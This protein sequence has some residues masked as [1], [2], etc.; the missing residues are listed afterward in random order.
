MKFSVKDGYDMD[1]LEDDNLVEKTWDEFRE[2]GLLWFVNRLIHVFG[3]AIVWD[4]DKKEMYPAHTKFRGFGPVSED[5][6]FVK[7]TKM[8]VND[9]ERFKEAFDPEELENKDE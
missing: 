3:W 6:G 4:V 7:I 2:S 9:I 8:M 5:S 1:D